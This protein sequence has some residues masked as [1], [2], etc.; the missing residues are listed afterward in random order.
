[1]LMCLVPSFTCT[2]LAPTSGRFWPGI[3]HMVIW[4][5]QYG[6][7]RINTIRRVIR[8]RRMTH[9]WFWLITGH[10]TTGMK[11]GKQSITARANMHHLLQCPS[12]Q[13]KDQNCFPSSAGLALWVLTAHM[14]LLWC[15][16]WSMT[17]AAC[18]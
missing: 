13:I 18:K 10:T 11:Q 3:C 4:D 15:C 2:P 5:V 8:I 7:I 9:P 17:S 16:V 1:M 12:T 14:P 6:K